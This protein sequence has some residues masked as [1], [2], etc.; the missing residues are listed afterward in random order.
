[1]DSVEPKP[2]THDGPATDD[3]IEFED[4]IL[5]GINFGTNAQLVKQQPL[6]F[7]TPAPAAQN[8]LTVE[9]GALP[10]VGQELRVRLVLAGDGRIQALS[11]PLTW[12]AGVV[13]PLAV[14]GGELLA[15]QGGTSLALSPR[16]G[17]VDIGLLGVRERGISGEG[18]IAEVGFRV[19]AAGAP[20][21]GV[22]AVRAR[23]PENQELDLSGAVDVGEVPE[24][25]PRVTQLHAPAPNPFNP[26][27][28]IAYDLAVGGRVTLRIY[29]IDG[30]LVRTLVDETALPGRYSLVWQG[31]DDGGRTVA[32]GTYVMRL[33]APGRTETRRMMLLK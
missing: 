19:L 30:R 1:V 16:P 28:T 33:V 3:A 6:A 25:L 32:S 22:G 29:S 27:T 9:V 10:P 26:A 4:L 8:R 7:T 31:R 21:I 20:G 24:A 11:V 2:T 15:A 12:N 13:E 18:V 23:T 17:S 14:R 5:F